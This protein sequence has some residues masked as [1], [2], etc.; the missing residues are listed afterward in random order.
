MY[1]CSF[2]QKIKDWREKWHGG[3]VPYGFVQL[4]NFIAPGGVNIRWHQTA[5]YGY[6]PNPSMENVFMAVA[7]DTYDDGSEPDFSRGIHSRYKQ[8]VGERLSISGGNVA[9]HLTAQPTNGP[10]PESI[11]VNN[12]YL[13]TINY[14]QTFSYSNAETSGFYI[15]C[16][17]LDECTTDADGDSI[18][19]WEELPK[20]SVTVENKKFKVDLTFATRCLPED[21]K[22]LGYIWAENPVKEYLSLPIYAD[23]EYRLPGAPWYYAL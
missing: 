14:D 12:N 9:Y 19:L 17:H 22:N 23:D 5:D 13:V 20:E 3:F 6:T 18:T 15:C 1:N 8:I 10:F 11:S 21:I 16:S 4:G 7:M 2:P